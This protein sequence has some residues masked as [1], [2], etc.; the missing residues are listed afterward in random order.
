MSDN[1]ETYTVSIDNNSYTRPSATSGY[2]DVSIDT[3][4]VTTTIKDDTGTP[5]TLSDGPETDHE[6]VIIKLVACDENGDPILVDDG[7]GNIIQ[8]TFANVAQEGGEANYMA[9]AFAPGETTFTTATTIASNG[10]VEV[11]FSD[12]SATGAS[13]QGTT[14]DGTKDYDNDGQ[15]VSIGTSFSTDIFD[16]YLKEGNHDF[17]VDI[18]TGSY[19]PPTGTTGYENVSENGSVTTTISDGDAGVGGTP[20]GDETTNEAID[21]VYVKIGD[22]DATTEGGSLTHTLSLVDKDGNAVTIPTGKTITVDLT[23]TSSNGVVDG[24]FNTIVKQVTITGNSEKEFTNITLDDFTVEGTENYTVEITGVNDDDSYFENVAIDTTNNTATGTI[25]DGVTLGVP[26]NASV[27]EDSFDMENGISSISDTKSL[28]I[29]APN[30]DNDYT[31]AFDGEPTFTS[32]D[33]TFN[34]VDG[35]SLTSDGTVLQYT[36]SGDTIT[37][38]AGTASLANKVFEI[39]LNKNTIGGADDS[40]TYTQYKNIDHPITNNDDDIVLNFKYKITDGPTGNVQTST[41]QDFTVTVGDSLPSGSTQNVTADEDTTGKVIYISDESFDGGEITLN[42][43]DGNQT[44]ANG[45]SINIYDNLTD[46]N[47]VGTLTNNGD[48]TLTFRP[49]ADFSGTTAGFSYTVSDGDGDS[50]S[51]NVNI[52]VTPIADTPDMNGANSGKSQST[53]K[54]TPQVLEDNNNNSSVESGTAYTALIGLILPQI[55]DSSDITAANSNDDQPE[56]LGLITLSS[57]TSETI[58]ASGVDYTVDSTGIKIFITDSPSIHYSGIDTTGAISLTQA[59]FEA[60]V[61]KFEN[62]NATN[63]KFT[64]SVDE[65]EVNDDNTLDNTVTK[66]S[67]SQDYEVD[68]LAVTDAISL[69]WDS[70]IDS[71]AND[72]GTISNANKTFTFDPVDE[73]NATIDLKSLLTKTSGLENDA[74]GDIDGSEHRSYT[75]S[76]LPDGSIVTFDGKEI[77]VGSSGTVTFDFPDNTKEDPDFSISIAEQYSGVVNGTITL[78]VTDTDDDSTGAISTET[79]SV[80]FTMTINPIAD[81]ATLQVAQAIGDED[82]GRTTGNTAND[83]T[84]DDIDAPQNGIPLDIEVSSSDTDG[85]ESFNVRIDEIPDGGSL[86]IYDNSLS[87]WVLVDKDF[88]DAGDITVEA[89][90]LAGTWKVIIEDYQND[91]ITKFIPPHNSDENYTFKVN[92]QTVDGSNTWNN[93]WLTLTDKDLQVTVND[94][95]DVP[96]GTELNLDGDG[97]SYT[98]VENTLDSGTNSF[99]LKDVY[100]NSANLDSYDSASENLS[101]VISDLPEG[102]SVT[103]ASIIGNGVWSFLATDIDNVKITTPTNFS[104]EATFDLKYITTENASDSKT[105]YTDTVKIFVSPSAE[106]EIS[107]ATTSNEDEVSKVNFAISYQ[108]G[109]TNETL[110][111]IRIKISDVESKDFTLYLG[112]DETTTLA[113]ALSSSIISDDGTYYILTATQADNVYV[114]NTNTHQHGSYSFEVGYS[115]KDTQTDTNTSDTKNGTIN[116]NLTINA[117][118]DTPSIAVETI[119]TGAGYS[120]SGTTVTVDTED[121]TFTI[122]VKMTSPDQDGSEDV[123]KFMISG[124]PM[125]VEVVGGTYYGYAGSEHNGIWILDI[126]DTAINSS[127]GYTENI[128]FKVNT[129][130]DFENRQIKIT[131]YT[132]DESASEESASTTI[133]IEKDYTAGPGVGTP[134]EF[135][136]GEKPATIL[137]DDTSYNLGESL[138]VSNVGGS[139]S[140]SY[141]ITITDLPTGTIVSGYDYSYEEGGVTRYVI[142]GTGNAADIETALSS[143]T[144][145][146]SENVNDTDSSTKSMSFTA[147]IATNDNGTYYQGNTINYEESILPVTDDMTIDIATSSTNEDTAT[148]F[149]ITLN[150]PADA[151]NTRLIDNK[152]YITITENYEGG[153]TAL[154]SLVYEGQTLT[155][156]G[157]GEYVID[158]PSGYTMGDSLDFTFNPGTNRHGTVSIEAVVKNYEYEDWAGHDSGQKD[159]SATGSITVVPVIDGFDENDIQDST[160]A[161]ATGTDKNIIEL[162]IA[163][164]LS[165]PSESMVSAT[166]DK[167]PNGFIIYYGANAA[168]A[169]IA[170]N[171]GSTGGSFVVNPNGDNTSVNFNQWLIPLTAGQLPPYIALQ[172]PENWSGTISDIT[173]NLFGISDGGESSNESY[174]FD[175]TF[176]PVADGI[177]IDPTQTFGD[178]FSWID[179]KLNANMVDVDGSETMSLKID[180]L[181]DM[182][183]FRLSDGTVLSQAT[184][185]EVLGVWNIDGVA[186]DQINNIQFTHSSNVT[187]VSVT[188]KTVDGTSESSE[189]IGS[190]YLTV[191]ATDNLTLES[192]INID[193]DKVD[194][195]SK[196]NNLS[197]IDLSQN[198]DHDILNL[199]LQ[200]V[201]DI[202][203]SS[204]ELKIIG[205][206]ADNVSLK[207]EGNTWSKVAGTGADSGFDIYSNSD[208]P[209][210]KVKVQTDISDNI[211]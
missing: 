207:N 16:D 119:G 8:Y 24:D 133:T 153:E 128:Q 196:L 45:N 82:A 146:P 173:L 175:V 89:G 53:I 7:S 165:D 141:A 2:E 192:S 138:T 25:R 168:S 126:A 140:G 112:D 147:T 121:T 130:A 62:D 52:S 118:T 10:T 108:N 22:N 72:L 109:D 23:Y 174:T 167:V 61:V 12:G 88:V 77:L 47:I 42:N 194:D 38:Y 87:S 122:P 37:A 57:S 102:F 190:F 157:S 4:S 139:N 193:F 160:T 127:S 182:S 54:T 188:A 74:D 186:Y 159:S 151:E 59:E 199:S 185:D 101:I 143:V 20:P 124:V 144:I 170:T 114:K 58:T 6:A 86:Y 18:T 176:T 55:S 204:K 11:T 76:G 104:G 191:S 83:N 154:G 68:I 79:T 210:V 21:T 41:S 142:V 35:D 120:V 166:L 92:A 206:N 187:G 197:E 78:N 26:T 66:A 48:G 31:L 145:R 158:L 179:L 39:K 189:E 28:N 40:Y 177:T 150:N 97:Y 164:A 19:T 98:N 115:V 71:N 113:D 64:V 96:V 3:S 17:S 60:I 202:T 209:T 155:K 201:L 111:E 90:S 93:T 152:V 29:T 75:L 30:D 203:G 125:G 195:L 36:V 43:G 103:G 94:I 161:E 184:Y 27:D 80:D 148:N 32:D 171:T 172:A 14:I 129:G 99:D 123:T 178:A 33:G 34:T 135:E 13:T 5:T 95:A 169:T 84:A 162:D 73:G 181:D 132:Q 85:S 134:P 44:I 100:Q 180:G 51:A 106:A 56:K 63:P 50:A 105:H 156:N 136:L 46:K 131:G 70:E 69:E 149:S 1:N 117:V 116:Y 9:V 67:N 163:T 49:T 200:D 91:N 205:D 198:G 137:E 110:E 107:N 183:Q 65:Y 211:V 208:D 81:I 15:T